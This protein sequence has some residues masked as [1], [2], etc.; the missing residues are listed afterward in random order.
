MKGKALA[1]A[2]T[3]MLAIQPEVPL[4]AQTRPAEPIQTLPAPAPQRPVPLPQPVPDPQR[5]VP[6]PQPVP[7]RPQRPIPLPEP[8]PP[9][10]RPPAGD[11]AGRI[12]CESRNNRTQRCNARTQNR[13]ELLTRS[14]ATC[15]R[16][17]SWGYD[18]RHIW[19][20]NNCRGT[21]GYGYGRGSGG[22]SSSGGRGL[23]AGAIIG[24]AAAAAGLIAI[25]NSRNNS[26]SSS[27]V[28]QGGVPPAPI[29]PAPEPTP[30]PLPQPETP[31]PPT[32]PFPAGP[33]AVI[34]AEL[35]SLPAAAR[36]PMNVCLAEAARQVG[37][38]GGTQL[39]FDRLTWIEPGNGGYRFRAQLVGTWPDGDRM[40]PLFCRATPTRVVELD[41]RE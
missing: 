26:S 17:R 16:G 11:F 23:S 31:P 7:D 2:A 25:L 20:S 14:S 28:S 24:G 12:T 27:S 4:S 36:P 10:V 32:A 9:S 33:P 18:D 21:F 15:V 3:T 30:T 41:F 37:I 39:R 13:V 22:G 35:S 1:I 29:P 8:V 34:V 5:P 40:L 19:V 38:T 6:L